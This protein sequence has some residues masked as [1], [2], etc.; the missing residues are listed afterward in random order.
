[1]KGLIA[2][3]K[4]KKEKVHN[5]TQRFAAYLN[6]FSAADKPSEHALIEYYTSALGPDLAMFSKRSVRPTLAET[7]EEA[8]KVEAEMESIE[9][10]RVQSEEKTFGN[11]KPLLLT[12]PKDEQSQDFEAMVKMMQKI[13]NRVIYL[14]RKKRLINHISLIIKK[15]K[16]TVNLNLLHTVLQQ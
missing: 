9:N 2:L 3:K 4:E 5:F 10:Y 15:G 14:E 1:M 13:S 8:E 16:I 12:K 6:N 11:K 7:Y